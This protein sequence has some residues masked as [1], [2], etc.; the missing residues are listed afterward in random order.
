MKRNQKEYSCGVCNETVF[1]NILIGVGFV[2]PK[3][4]TH[5]RRD[6]IGIIITKEPSDEWKNRNVDGWKVVKEFQLPPKYI[7]IFD[8]K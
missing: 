7:E 1:P 4:K 8:L 3:C 2:C 6:D 5:F